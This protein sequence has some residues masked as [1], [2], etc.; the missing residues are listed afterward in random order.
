M[1]PPI[2]NEAKR[3]AHP[4]KPPN[5]TVASQVGDDRTRVDVACW[6]ICRVSEVTIAFAG[7]HRLLKLR[8]VC[9]LGMCDVSVDECP[10]MTI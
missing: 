1:T 5:R 6:A 3:T 10:S 2:E 9:E 7:T 8:A 4:M